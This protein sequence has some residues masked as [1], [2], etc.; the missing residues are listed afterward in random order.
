MLLKSTTS[1]R[2]S[3][4][5]QVVCRWDNP[6]PLDLTVDCVTLWRLIDFSCCSG[7]FIRTLKR[8]PKDPKAGYIVKAKKQTVNV[9]CAVPYELLA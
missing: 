7:T 9:M 2:Q 3:E 6:T 4:Q 5:V 1:A 8:L